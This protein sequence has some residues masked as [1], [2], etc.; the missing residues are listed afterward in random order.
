MFGEC[1]F[2]KH[3]SGLIR[4]L[5]SFKIELYWLNMWYMLW[6]IA[7]IKTFSLC[8]KENSIWWTFNEVQ[9]KFLVV[10]P[11]RVMPVV[12]QLSSSGFLCLC[13]W[14]GVLNI[15]DNYDFKFAAT[16]FGKIGLS[17]PLPPSWLQVEV[18]CTISV[19]LAAKKEVEGLQYS[20]I[21]VEETDGPSRVHVSGCQTTEVPHCLSLFIV[22]ST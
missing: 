17:L 6:I 10:G 12:C 4:T 8:L 20:V 2:L 9:E 21:I 1:Y 3:K 5:N 11:C 14:W 16:A 7:V 18:T 13:F 19:S 22:L 15:K